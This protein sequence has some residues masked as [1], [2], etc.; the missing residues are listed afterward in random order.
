M[1]GD[2]FEI[3]I[4]RWQDNRRYKMNVEIIYESVQVIRFKI[5]SGQKEMIME[6]LLIKKTNPW[7]IKEMNFKFGDDDKYTAM[8]IM[9]I[10]DASEFQIN[11]PRP[12]KW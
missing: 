1:I 5:H 7:K 10:Q 6:K 8:S 4:R 9:S 2:K 12:G 3:I 11:P